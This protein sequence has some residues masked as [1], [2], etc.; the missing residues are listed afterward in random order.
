M[1]KVGDSRCGMINA[2]Q[3]RIP[4]SRLSPSVALS[5]QK[6][7]RESICMAVLSGS[8]PAAT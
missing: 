8:A 1:F 3:L 5:L 4:S 6:L 7:F 2:K